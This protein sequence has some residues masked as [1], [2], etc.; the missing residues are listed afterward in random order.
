[1]IYYLQDCFFWK[2]FNPTMCEIARYVHF[3]YI[4]ACV[5]FFALNWVIFCIDLGDDKNLITT[6]IEVCPCSW[7][8]LHPT[9][10][11]CNHFGITQGKSQ[12]TNPEN[13]TV[14]KVK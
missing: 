3:R 13:G 1:M 6:Y 8:W 7:Q 5:D 12:I 10:V 14:Q 2:F 9:A 4:S 11:Q